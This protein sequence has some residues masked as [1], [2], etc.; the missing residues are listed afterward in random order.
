MLSSIIRAAAIATA[1]FGFTSAQAQN[2][3]AIDQSYGGFSAK[4]SSAG[5]L[6]VRHRAF[7]VE[8]KLVICGAYSSQG[9]SRQNRFAQ[10]LLKESSA[11]LNGRSVMR[12][13]SFFAVVNSRYNS[14]K[15]EGQSANCRGTNVDA[16]QEM[17][18]TY[19]FDSGDGRVRVRR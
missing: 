2:A 10:A 14:V 5:G 9:G 8:G 18:S 3:N 16:T 11:T 6:I 15:L 19:A 17:L 13:M 4:W 1:L 12:D 7:V